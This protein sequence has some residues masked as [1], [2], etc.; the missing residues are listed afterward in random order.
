[1]LWR[2]ALKVLDNA[3]ISDHSFSGLSIFFFFLEFG[4]CTQITPC[5]L[6]KTSIYEPFKLLYNGI[7]TVI[8]GSKS[9]TSAY[10]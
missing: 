5:W 10:A 6:L 2:W 7:I 8:T 3:K 9:L 1:M 4:F